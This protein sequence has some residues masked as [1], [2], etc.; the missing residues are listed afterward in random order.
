[1]TGPE[2]IA[3]YQFGSRKKRPT[4]DVEIV[5]FPISV[6][7]ACS[8]QQPR[9]L[10]RSVPNCTG[11]RHLAQRFAI[12]AR[13]QSRHLRRVFF[14]FFPKGQKK[15]KNGGGG[16]TGLR[17][18]IRPIRE[19]SD[20]AAKDF[21]SKRGPCTVH[22]TGI[23][24]SKASSRIGIAWSPRLSDGCHRC[25]PRRRMGDRSSACHREIDSGDRGLRTSAA[26][27]LWANHSSPHATTS[28]ARDW[29]RIMRMMNAVFSSVR[30]KRRSSFQRRM[31]SPV[32]RGK[33]SHRNDFCNCTSR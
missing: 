12:L 20:A 32:V 24:S 22:S 31:R 3:L 25:H 26:Q 11:I 4:R 23:T 5:W 21:L 14:F 13:R 10:T 19:R 33:R 6:R 27:S 30:L 8:L 1:M 18:A 2:K 17:T 15:P 9:R 7:R 16:E 29:G 28:L